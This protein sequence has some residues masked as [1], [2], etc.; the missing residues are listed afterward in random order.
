[1]GVLGP[2]SWDN[3]AVR[4]DNASTSALTLDDV[5]A[6][7]G[8]KHFDQWGS[9]LTAPAGGSLVVTQMADQSMDTSEINVPSCTLYGT[10][11]IVHVKLNGVVRNYPDMSQI[12]N[13]PWPPSLEVPQKGLLVLAGLVGHSLTTKSGYTIR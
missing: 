2:F 7:I 3:G 13:T 4:V 10:I 1:M 9:N 6:D 8:A 11:R 12:I 5:S